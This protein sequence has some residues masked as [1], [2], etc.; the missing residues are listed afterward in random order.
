LIF[1][2][3]TWLAAGMQL[4]WKDEPDK[5]LE[6]DL[7]EIV[8]TLS[9]AGPLLAKQWRE[10]EEAEQRRRE[11]EHQRYLE[12]QFREEDEKRWRRFLEIAHRCEQA[13]NA[14]RLLADLAARSQ[15]EDIKI[16]GHPPSEWFAW[17]SDWLERF[18]PLK[19]KP[20]ELLQEL[21]NV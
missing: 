1:T 5:P 21:V 6:N 18:D 3:K 8:A 17:A 20:E 7:S 9:L 11:E 19:R 4:E 14:R 12:R 13:A 15:P 16:G 10:R 2:I